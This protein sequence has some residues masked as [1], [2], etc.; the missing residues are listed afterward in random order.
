[1]SLEQRKKMLYSLN[2]FARRL[3]IKYTG[4]NR[5]QYDSTV[6]LFDTALSAEDYAR[7]KLQDSL[8]NPD[9]TTRDRD[10]AMVVTSEIV[11]ARGG[12]ESDKPKK[13]VK[14]LNLGGSRE[15]A[16]SPQEGSR[17]PAPP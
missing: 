12:S 1:M 15:A 11:D 6:G 17:K 10:N 8:L 14:I 2:E 4:L 7:M 9:G 13:H 16:A 3:P 5:H